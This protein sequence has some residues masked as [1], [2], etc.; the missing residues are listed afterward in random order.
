MTQTPKCFGDMVLDAKL[1]A[2]AKYTI[3]HL[4]QSLPKEGDRSDILKLLDDVIARRSED[5]IHL[6]FQE[7]ANAG[8]TDA[9]REISRSMTLKAIIFA[10]TNFFKEHNR[11]PEMS[12]EAS[13]DEFVFAA[14]VY[15]FMS[16][17]DPFTR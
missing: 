4:K 5:L 14:W 13:T 3:D 7:L 6:V 16:G 15:F 8:M 10:F 2:K 12:R 11:F 17:P 1:E 9:L